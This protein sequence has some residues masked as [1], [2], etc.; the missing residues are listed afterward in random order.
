M[1][2]TMLLYKSID[3]IYIIYMYYIYIYI[4]PIDNL[5]FLLAS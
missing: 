3:V 4:N 5:L 2:R 1:R